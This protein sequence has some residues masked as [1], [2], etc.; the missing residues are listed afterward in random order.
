MDLTLAVFGLLLI[1]IHLH[2]SISCL[3][4]F[5]C[6]QVSV[7]HSGLLLL[8]LDLA[9]SYNPQTFH[10]LSTNFCILN[11]S[12]A[13]R[14]ALLWSVLIFSCCYGYS[15]GN[16]NTWNSDLPS[17]FPPPLPP[18]NQENRK[19]WKGG[20]NMYLFISSLPY[21]SGYNVKLLK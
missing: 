1:V 9:P 14:S 19:M 13:E 3:C 4:F 12:P 18:K 20:E 6:L 5:L 15:V 10:R 7:C 21:G 2:K 11:L 16:Q 8:L 17:I